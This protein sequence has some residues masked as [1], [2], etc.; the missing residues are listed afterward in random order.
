MILIQIEFNNY[1]PKSL[2][3]YCLNYLNWL[4]QFKYLF[5]ELK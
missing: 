2:K 5:S 1:S 3:K 4:I